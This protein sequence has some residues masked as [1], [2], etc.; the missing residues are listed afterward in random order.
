[1][2]TS[3]SKQKLTK[4]ETNKLKQVL[5]SLEKDPRSFDFLEPVDYISNCDNLEYNLPDYPTLIKRPMDLGTIKKN[6]NAGK[7]ST[8]QSVCDDIQLVWNN[9][10]TYNM[11]GSVSVHYI[12]RYTK[13]PR[14]LRN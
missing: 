11:Q 3:A 7:Y 10:K 6:L 9:C 2:H 5:S 8:V 1:M 4:D 12:R 13:W 14:R